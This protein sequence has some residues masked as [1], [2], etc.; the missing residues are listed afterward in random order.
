MAVEKR[1]AALKA[2]IKKKQKAIAVHNVKTEKK[3]DDARTKRLL[4]K[5]RKAR[6][7]KRKK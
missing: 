4:D 3:L 5:T 7:A 6:N 2:K 1:T